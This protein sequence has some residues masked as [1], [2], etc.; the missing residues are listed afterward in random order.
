MI[1]DNDYEWP[2]DKDV[3]AGSDVSV[4]T[5][6]EGLR[7]TTDAVRISG[8]PSAQPQCNVRRM[9]FK[10]GFGAENPVVPCSP[11]RAAT[12][13]KSHSTVTTFQYN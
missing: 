10:L 7:K 11:C 8:V 6:L 12:P 13:I 9:L 4:S 1:T 3:V 2:Y 5:P